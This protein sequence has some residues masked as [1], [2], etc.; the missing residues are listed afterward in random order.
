MNL[1][2]LVEGKR[3]EIKVYPRWLSHL[4]PELNRVQWAH[5]VSD[6]NY[7]IFNGNGFPSLLH[8]HLKNSIEEVNDINLFKYLIVVL[9]VDESSVD[10]RKREVTTFISDNNLNLRNT[11]LVIIPQNRCI[12]TWFLGNRR[13]YKNNPQNL[14]LLEFI[15][16][17]NVQTLDPEEM[18][19]IV[20]FNTH[21]QFHYEYCKLM[22]LERNIRYSKKNPQGVTELTFLDRLIERI[23]TTDHLNSFSVFIE[24]CYKVRNELHE[25]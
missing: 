2:F 23:Q 14:S 10:I 24:F 12:E 17:Y 20:D 21:S 3:T 5:Q 11:E 6:N 4:I 13:V 18:G 22:L 19:F 15:N 7:F 25:E 16:F 9:D 8:N 1:Y